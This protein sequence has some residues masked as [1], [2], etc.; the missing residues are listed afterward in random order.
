MQLMFTAIHLIDPITAGK[1]ELSLLSGAD[2]ANPVLP[3]VHVAPRCTSP[4]PPL[5]ILGSK[6]L[7][8]ETQAPKPTNL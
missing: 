3:A 1:T 6:P 8:M 7:N 5:P 2:S 4:L